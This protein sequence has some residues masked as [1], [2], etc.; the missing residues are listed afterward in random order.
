M[1]SLLISFVVVLVALLFASP[2]IASA[3]S[4]GVNIATDTTKMSVIVQ[5]ADTDQSEHCAHIP[6]A[7]GAHSH[8]SSTC[9]AHS[10]VAN[11]DGCI[12]LDFESTASISYKND[13]CVGLTLLPPVPPPLA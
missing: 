7:N 13:H 9:S 10:F 12:A 8:T 6:C 11:C 2:D 1:R 5:S 3:M 4:F